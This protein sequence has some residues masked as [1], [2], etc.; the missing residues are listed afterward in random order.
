MKLALRTFLALL[1]APCLCASLLAQGGYVTEKH[2]DLGVELPRARDY[3]QV[4]TQ[5]DEEHVILYYVEKASK[6]PKAARAPRGELSVVWI[7]FVPDPPPPSANPAPQTPPAPDDE[8]RSKAKP[9]ETAP[10]PPPK[11]PINSIERFLEQRTRWE[12]GRSEAGKARSGYPARVVTLVPREVNG[13]RSIGYSAW[14]YLFELPSKR[15]IAFVGHCSGGDMTEA[16]KIWR[17]IAE[18]AE[19][20]EPAGANLAKIQ[21]K[22]RNSNLRG[23]EFRAKARSQL[24]RGWKAEDTENFIVVHHT[25]DQPLVRAICSD[26]EAIRKEYL[27]LFPPAGPIEAVS[28]VRVCKDR[29]EYMAYG[30]MPGSAG[31]WNSKSE[32]LVFYDATIKEKGKRESGEENTFIVLYHEAL[33]QYIYYSA[34]AVP[35]HYWFNEG[36]GDFFSGADIK[37]GKVVSIG[38]NPWRIGYI[39]RLVEQNKIIRW[40]DILSFERAQFYDPSKIGQ[41]YAQAWS[42][43]YFLRKSPAATK[44]AQWSKILDAYFVALKEDYGRRVE[45]L[46]KQGRAAQDDLREDAGQKARAYAL[47]L[48]FQGVDVDALEEAWREF[49]EKLEYKAK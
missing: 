19:F 8:G 36:H 4:P 32:E 6:D 38:L 15:T 35:P 23:L 44:H 18:H 26:I 11:P 42:M 45:F 13:Q 25:P 17:Y 16:T 21:E 14:A 49:V 30:G 1:V 20:S 48:A 28:V 40:K 12:L 46:E 27:K 47:E 9:M 29:G 22:Y 10:A 31:Y 43:V 7:D 24:V 37:S 33:H 5:P 3:E 41:C 34:G 39:K 2:P